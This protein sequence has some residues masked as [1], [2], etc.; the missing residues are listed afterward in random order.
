MLPR[1]SRRPR[2]CVHRFARACGSR[3]VVGSSR[4]TRRG[5]WMSPSAM[6]SRRRWPPDSVPHL[7]S[8]SPSSSSWPKQLL[9]AGDR[10]GPLDAVEQRV[11]DDLLARARLAGGGPGL[12]D[13]ADAAPDGAGVASQ[14]GAGDGRVAAGRAQQ[15]REHAQRR[16]LAGPV[17]AEEADDLA[18]VDV[19]VDATHGVD[20][21]STGL[22][23]AGQAAGMD[24]AGSPSVETQVFKI[25][26][27]S[28]TLTITCLS[29]SRGPA[30]STRSTPGPTPASRAAS[31]CSGV[32]VQI[33][34]SP[35]NP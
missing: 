17:R 31:T 34:G 5:V 6:S 26:Y 23:G 3:P 13:V 10:D 8:Q 24:H 25:D 28:S 16:G 2:T 12:G 15:R 7:R 30:A 18:G 20:V 32:G 35:S 14:V 22:V 1:V 19:E 4:N 11:V 9:A 21:T 33:G 27:Y 29:Q